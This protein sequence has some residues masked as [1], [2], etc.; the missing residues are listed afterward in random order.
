[1]SIRTF[2]TIAMMA[3][4][5]TVS[6]QDVVEKINAIKLD[7]Q[8][9]YGEASHENADTAFMAA[10]LDLKINLEAKLKKQLDPGILKNKVQKLSR[11]RGQRV[12][13]M[14]YIKNEDVSSLPPAIPSIPTEPSKEDALEKIV[15]KPL[16]VTPSLQTPPPAA[17]ST[18]PTMP[19]LSSLVGE[20]MDTEHLQEALMVLEGHTRRGTVGKFVPY[21]KAQHP[22][23]MY[24]LIFDREYNIPLAV[25]TP[26]KPN[27]TRDNLYKNV[28]DSL[29]N[30]SDK[31]A[32]CFTIK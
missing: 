12:K 20:L 22:Q 28:E 13:V 8:Y 19:M 23:T 25:L 27:G 5:A 10:L 30:Y 26:E 17:A 21:S 18:A 11:P 9:I 16:Q 2:I 14:A 32:V 1:M 31:I 29:S 7:P 15:M 4:T 24:L 3:A 6:A